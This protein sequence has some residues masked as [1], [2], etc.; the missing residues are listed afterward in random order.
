M[1]FLHFWPHRIHLCCD[2]TYGRSV[3]LDAV[4]RPK[5][6]P[7]AL[8]VIETDSRRAPLSAPRMQPDFI[9]HR[10]LM[11]PAW[12]PELTD[13]SRVYDRSRGLQIGRAHV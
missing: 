9:R 1:S 12:E 10:L 2:A 5:F 6:D 8:P 4:M 11:P 3:I 13:E 7:E